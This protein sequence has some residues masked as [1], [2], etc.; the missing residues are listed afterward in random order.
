MRRPRRWWLS[1]VISWSSGA[2][3]TM[4]ILFEDSVV[5]QKR[6]QSGWYEGW[7]GY[8]HHVCIGCIHDWG[9]LQI[10]SPMPCLSSQPGCWTYAHGPGWDIWLKL[11]HSEGEG[12]QSLPGPLIL[13]IKVPHRRNMHGLLSNQSSSSMYGCTMLVLL[14]GDPLGICFALVIFYHASTKWHEKRPSQLKLSY[15]LGQLSIKKKSLSYFPTLARVWSFEALST[16]AKLSTLKSTFKCGLSLMVARQDVYI[17]NVY[18]Y[19]VSCKV[20]YLP[21]WMLLYEYP[22][23]WMPLVF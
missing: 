5:L 19:K 4:F 2:Q 17:G 22:L 6:E 3:V 12:V 20:V 8:S 1:D 23:L 14:L 7:A 21:I 16:L 10:Q 11:S 9:G 13:P 18:W 15:S